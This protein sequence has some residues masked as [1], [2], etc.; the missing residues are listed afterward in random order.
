MTSTD[1]YKT[2]VATFESI[3]QVGRRKITLRSK[4]SSKTDV[5]ED[6]SPKAL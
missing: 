5:T 4:A 3:P 6:E 1:H 2:Y